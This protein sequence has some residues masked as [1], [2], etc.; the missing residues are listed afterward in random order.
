M[1]EHGDGG[2]EGLGDDGGFQVGGLVG[3]AG[4][5][6]DDIEQ[7]LHAAQLFADEPK[8][9]VGKFGLPPAFGKEL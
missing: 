5:L 6:D 9:L 3:R 1:T 4:L 8:K 2:L 7:A